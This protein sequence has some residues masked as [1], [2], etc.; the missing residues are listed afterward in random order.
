MTMKNKTSNSAKPTGMQIAIASVF[1]LIPFALF[2]IFGPQGLLVCE[3]EVPSKTEKSR[4]TK[5]KKK[6]K[7]KKKKTKTKTK[8]EKRISLSARFLKSRVCVCMVLIAIVGQKVLVLR[9]CTYAD[10]QEL[11]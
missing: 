10:L 6:K 3:V 1:L 7:K 11:G 2:S 4:T 5:S 8:N 9:S